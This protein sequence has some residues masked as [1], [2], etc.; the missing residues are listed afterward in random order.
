M[1]SIKFPVSTVGM[2]R[3]CDFTGFDDELNLAHNYLLNK[4]TD[5]SPSDDQSSFQHRDRK[6]GPACC[7]LTG[8]GGVGKTQIALEYTYR[9]Q[10]EYDAIFWLEAQYDWTLTANYAQISDALALL[11][12]QDRDGRDLKQQMLTTE[13]AR[14]WPQSTGERLSFI[15]TRLI[16]ESLERNWLLVF[17]NVEDI[18]DIIPYVPLKTRTRGSVLITTQR[19]INLEVDLDSRTIPI[20]SF[21]RDD[22]VALFFKYLQRKPADE[23][24][25]EMAQELSDMIEGLPLAIATIGGYLKC[26]RSNLAKYIAALKSSSNAWAASAVGPANQYEKNLETVFN[27][28]ITELSENAQGVLAILAFLSPDRIPQELFRKAIEIGLI[29]SLHSE[30]DLGEMLHEL[31]GRQLIQTEVFGPDAFITIHRTLQWNILLF[32]SKDHARRWE[33][34]QQAFRLIKEN[35]PQE[36]PFIIPSLDK[37]PKFQEYEPHI[38]SLREHCLWPDP[39]VE[40]PLNFAKVLSDIGTYMWHAGKL[41]E[42]EEALKT[43]ISIMDDNDLQKDDSMRADVYELLG[44]MSSFDGVSE[45]TKSMNLRYKALNARKHSYDAIPQGQAT[46]DDEIKRWIVESDVAYG[47][48]QQEDFEGAA[49]IMDTVQKKYHEWGSE[50]EYRYQYSQYYQILAVC[51]MAAGEPAKSIDHITRC[52]ELVEK[53]ST[54]M[55]PMTQLMRFIAGVLTWHAGER[56]KALEIHESVLEARRKVIGEFSHSTLESYS[57]CAKLLAEG[58][59]FRKAR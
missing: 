18:N 58:G 12:P 20:K 16:D 51:L 26:S 45:R 39:P 27:T 1:S 11:D 32:L 36:S 23:K 40:L 28:A 3:N 42:G 57:T 10:T 44:I 37:W 56:K 17:D 2:N 54:H 30:T 55:H 22:A 34:F 6:T 47:L 19:Q 48:V 15:S 38:L 4:G 52:V 31:Q 53:S 14:D 5:Q 33:V 50:D 49:N 25:E 8:I 41:P 24:E 7:V 29:E 46:R 35:L 9:Y 59:D 43:A 13:K 21:S